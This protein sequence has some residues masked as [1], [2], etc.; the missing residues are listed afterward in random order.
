[1]PPNNK[2]KKKPA[3]NPA[4]GF[5]TV[6]VP[7]KPKAPEPTAS[8][9]ATPESKTATPESD[10]PAAPTAPAAAEGSQQ[11]S[12]TQPKETQSLQNYSP[13]ELGRHLEESQLQIL[14]EKYAAKCK[15]DAARHVTKLETERRIMR[16]QAASLNVFEWLPTEV[17]NRILGLLETEEC[18]L[19]PQPGAK[20]ALSEEDLCMRLWTLKET[21]VKLGF[22]EVKVDESLKH[23]L[24]YFAGNPVP[25]SRDRDILW[26]MDE[27]LDWLAL[28]C[29]PGELPSYA[30][31]GAALPK[32]ADKTVSWI[33]GKPR[34]LVS[35]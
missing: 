4:R 10:Q 11:P 3:A 7:S 9:S 1:M 6:S 8:T 2:K 22:P 30:R 35:Q 23:L 31:T 14:V 12:E 21:L 18:E 17:L 33:S 19:S 24:L 34:L 15:N 28:H 29:G 20:R 27:L 25:T 5:A 26:N 32:D 16:Q 13:E